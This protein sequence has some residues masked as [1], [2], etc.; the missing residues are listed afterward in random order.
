[1]T[2]VTFDMATALA[3]SSVTMNGSGLTFTQSNYEL[4]IILPTTLSTGTTATVIITYAGSPP[5]AE[6]AFTRS[7]HAGTPVIYTLSE[8]FGARDWWPC[9]QDLNDK[10]DSFDIYI[11]CLLILE[12]QMGCC[13]ALPPQAEIPHAI[14]DTIIPFRR[15]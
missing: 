5:Q 2:T 13:K 15:I 9:K 3:V 11:T 1:M 10:I 14:I 6:A 12:Y 7:T 8:P 4:N